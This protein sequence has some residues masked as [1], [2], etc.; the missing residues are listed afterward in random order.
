MQGIGLLQFTRIVDRPGLQLPTK[1]KCQMNESTVNETNRQLR[2]SGSAQPAGR[3][4]W[5]ERAVLPP[6][7]LLKTVRPYA[8][9]VLYPKYRET[10]NHVPLQR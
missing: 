5:L 8:L 10:V 2:E 3:L 1:A 9:R 6:S 7:D 4:A